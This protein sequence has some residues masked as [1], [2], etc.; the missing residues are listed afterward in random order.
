MDE[1]GAVLVKIA[2]MS[3]PDRVMAERSMPSS[4]QRAGP[5]AEFW[6]GMPAYAEDG[7]VV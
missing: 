2:E 5:L 3:E 4:S 1:E 7:K 6:Y